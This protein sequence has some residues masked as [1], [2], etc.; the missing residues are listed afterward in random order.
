[1]RASESKTKITLTVLAAAMPQTER[2]Q[3]CLSKARFIPMT[4]LLAILKGSVRS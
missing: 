3:L 4:K 1:M 2:L